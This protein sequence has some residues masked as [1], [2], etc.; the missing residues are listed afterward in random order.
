MTLTKKRILCA[1]GVLVLLAAAVLL[2][3]KGAHRAEH[4]AETTAQ[5]L[6]LSELLCATG[7]G[8]TVSAEEFDF[9]YDMVKRDSANRGDAAALTEETQTFIREQS[10]MLCAAELAG[11]CEPYSFESLR[12]NMEAENEK[13]AEMKASGEVFYG[14]ERFDLESYYSYITSN[15]RLDLLAY[16]VEQATDEMQEEGR[17]YYEEHL[18]DYQTIETASYIQEKN[19]EE[20]EKRLTLSDMRSLMNTNEELFEFL[21]SAQ[22]G[23]RLTQTGQD[24]EQTVFT[25]QSLEML[26]ASFEEAYN[27]AMQDYIANEKYDDILNTVSKN[28][29]VIFEK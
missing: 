21:L 8:R 6:P 12:Q 17:R 16:F 1:L 23:D 5:P 25:F 15:L 22:P 3:W 7:H 24:G 11:L 20:E 2:L 18:S 29:P 4:A 19:G 10:A 26:T 9:F 28:N 13:R 27:V 14:L